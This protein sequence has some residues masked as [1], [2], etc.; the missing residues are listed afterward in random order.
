MGRMNNENEVAAILLCLP[1]HI[2]LWAIS[3]L[4]GIWR[5]LRGCTGAADAGGAIK[6]VILSAVSS[7]ALNLIHREGGGFDPRCSRQM[8]V[9]ARPFDLLPAETKAEF[10]QKQYFLLTNLLYEEKQHG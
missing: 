4:F 2:R 7:G 5:H 6:R 8:Y 3:N 10:L 1:V 9:W